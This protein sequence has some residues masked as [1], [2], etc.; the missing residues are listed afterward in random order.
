[1]FQAIS[2]VTCPK[3][4]KQAVDIWI[5]FICKGCKSIIKLSIM[6]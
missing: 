5:V 6:K 2:V 3:K 4:F 1:M